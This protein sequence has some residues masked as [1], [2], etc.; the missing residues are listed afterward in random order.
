MAEWSIAGALQMLIEPKSY[1]GFESRW[2]RQE[3]VGCGNTVG[4]DFFEKLALCEGSLRRVAGIRLKIPKCV[5][6]TLFG[7]PASRPENARRA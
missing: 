3:A 4:G 2:N 7:W 1:P 5:F 6:R